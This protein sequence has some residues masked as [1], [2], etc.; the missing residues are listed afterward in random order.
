MTE[1]TVSVR[2]VA[3]TS[4]YQAQMARAAAATR[5]LG[6]QMGQTEVST[7]GISKTLGAMGM[8]AKLGM[9]AGAL[10]AYGLAKGL[11]SSVNAAIDFE[12]S[13][14]G[15]RK[16]VDGT[17]EELD[18]VADGMRRLATE[19][20]VNVNE[21]NRIG[22]LGGQLGVPIG[23]LVEF[24][25]VIA[26]MGETTDLAVEDA[27]M[28]FAR[29]SA[30]TGMPVSQMENLASSV[31]ALGNNLSTTEPDIVS[32]AQRI[33]GA[34]EIAGLTEADIMGIAG[35][36]TS[37]VPDIEA[38]G[39]AV[40]KVLL[41]L[42]ESVVTSDSKLEMFAQTAG[43]SATDF[44]ETWRSNPAEAFTSFVG[45][46]TK[47]GGNAQIVLKNLDLT[48]QRLVRTFL[49]LAGAGKK[50]SS[51]VGL[52]NG[53]F[54]E[55]NALQEEA[56]KRFETTASKIELANN[57]VEEAKIAFGEGLA[58][59]L[60]NAAEFFTDV[61]RASQ[62]MNDSLIASTNLFR[63][64]ANSVQEGTTEVD[65]FVQAVTSQIANLDDLG[66]PKTLEELRAQLVEFTSE[67]NALSRSIDPDTI[68]QA[69]GVID[70]IDA[71]ETGTP[72]MEDGANALSGV[73]DAAGD[74]AGQMDD[75]TQKTWDQITALEQLKGASGL[76]SVQ[77]ALYGVTEA[78][79]RLTDAQRTVNELVKDGK[80]GT[81]EYRDALQ[82]RKEASLGVLRSEF[83]LAESVESLREKVESGE[84]SMKGATR[85]I[86]DFGEKNNLSKVYVEGLIDRVKGLT[87]DLDGLP[88]KKKTDIDVDT[89]QGLSELHGWERQLSKIP[90]NLTTTVRIQQ[91]GGGGAYVNHS[92]GMAG[93]G[94]RRVSGGLKSDEIP[95]I[96]Q[97]GELV[98]SKAQMRERPVAVPH[99]QVSG[100]GDSGPTLIELGVD[101]V[102]LTKTVRLHEGTNKVLLPGRS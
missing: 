95:T 57:Q 11:M 27:A 38:G 69:L 23:D 49:S 2:L 73:G 14:A 74:A 53:S 101:G 96:L 84:V 9:G 50:L 12:S 6:T 7:K 78:Q 43:M 34:G 81:K 13:F 41:R 46:L 85:I 58:L 40:Q 29:F 51:S 30:V 20:P 10:A 28:S 48:D 52:A 66:T 72:V 1:R 83:T 25:K 54:T 44:A 64:L 3:A 79:H 90:T 47:A 35:A 21:L 24:T 22:E 97:R 8:G 18:A 60:G 91:V 56:A 33:A 39:T 77:D 17:G 102:V 62:Y 15:I 70:L 98:I 86:K 68:D 4:L 16:T 61:V 31:V 65:V 67:A 45:G 75:L 36:V 71:M 99:A 19:I 82:D 76:L 93:S 92:G 59:A 100:G 63:Q 5:A 80:K 37:V 42:N 87:T 55:G 94:P 26:L 88:R 89:S 32:F